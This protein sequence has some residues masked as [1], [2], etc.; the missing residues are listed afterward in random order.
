MAGA[1]TDSGVDRR[2]LIRRAAIV[3]AAAWT[4]PVIIGS[5]SSPAAAVTA[6]RGCNKIGYNGNC[7]ANTNNANNECSPSTGTC[8]DLPRACLS[9]TVSDCDG[10]PGAVTF[11]VNGG[12]SCTIIAIGAKATNTTQQN[13][14][15]CI[16]T[17]TITNGGKGASFPP[18]TASGPG[19]AGYIQ[20]SFQLTCG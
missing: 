12:C 2:T 18:L 3:G 6:P 19:N 7:N 8:A 4:A 9:P 17:G 14:N 16:T 1:S 11:A 10:I 5:L 15:G 13:A 20:F